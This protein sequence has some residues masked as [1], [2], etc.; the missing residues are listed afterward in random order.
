M[1]DLMRRHAYS[2]GTRILLG[3]I[4]LVFVFWGLGSGLFSQVHPV[5]TV[6]GERILPDQVDREADRLRRTIQAMYGANA[7]AALKNVN[8]REEALDQILERELVSREARHLGLRVDNQSLEQKISSQRAFQVDG[9]FDVQAY[10]EVLRE[11]GMTPSDYEDGM[12][13]AMIA[14]TLQHMIE[15]GINVS[16]DEVRQAYNLRNQRIGLAYLELPWLQYSAKINP[17]AQQIADYYKQHAEAFREPERAMIEFIHYQPQALAANYTPSDQEIEEYYRRNLK[18]R[19]T[20]PDL[21]HAQHILISVPAGATAAEKAAAKAKAE[22]ILKQ[23]QKGANFNE[24]AQ[25]YSDD[26]SNKGKGGDLGFFPRGQM[27]KPFEDAVFKMKPGEIAIVETNFGYHV[28]KVDEV[29]AAHVDTLQEARP[30]IIQEMRDQA[31]AKLARQSVDEDLGAALNGATLQDLAKKRGLDVAEPPS[32][33]KGEPVQGVSPESGLSQKA[34]SM[35]KGQVGTVPGPAPFLIKVV[36][37]SP[38]TIP[39][40]KDIEAKVRDAYVRSIAEADARA[41]ARKLIA[42]VKTPADFKSVAESNNLTIHNVD[43]FE[44]SSS[45][46]PGIGQFPEVTDATGAVAQV[47]GVIDRVMEQSGNSY[48]FELTSRSNPSDEQWNGAKDSFTEEY[49]ALRRSQA[50]TR[51]LE[52]LKSKAK[53]TINADQLAATGSS[54]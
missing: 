21:V 38:S 25:K 13:T 20:H 10:Q 31:G 35:E 18:A 1:L 9:H 48:I 37:K 6:D 54:T 36:Q 3:F 27:I 19:F 24:L 39:P 33:A 45:S 49:L 43:P 5:A 47:P 4:T 8:L 53:I 22:D 32:F 42:Q 41:E 51:Y 15:D 2:W 17:T 40:L 23:L 26:A 46:V 7:A 14:D 34:F 28:V 16:E 29:K 30:K 50:W 44:R 12:R 11:N 52:E